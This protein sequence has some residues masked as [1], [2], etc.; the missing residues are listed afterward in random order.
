MKKTFATEEPWMLVCDT[1]TV[2]LSLVQN[3]NRDSPSLQ[4]IFV[5]LCLYSMYEVCQHS[6]KESKAVREKLKE[7]TIGPRQVNS[8][9]AINHNIFFPILPVLCTELCFNINHNIFFTSCV[10]TLL[11]F[12]VIHALIVT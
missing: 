12:M 8:S 7:G 11:L 2:I 9:E 5:V 6:T 3:N 1:S 4:T 10:L